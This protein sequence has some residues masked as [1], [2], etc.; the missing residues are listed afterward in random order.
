ME[1]KKWKSVEEVHNHAKKAVNK[2]IK[3]LT[4]QETVE[5]YYANT[6]NKGGLATQLKVIGSMFLI[7]PEKKQIFPT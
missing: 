1:N 4:T 2:K 5:K 3:D 6:K 7:I